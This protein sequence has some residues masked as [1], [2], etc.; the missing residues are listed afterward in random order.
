MELPSPDKNTEQSIGTRL[1]TVDEQPPL[2]PNEEIDAQTAQCVGCFALID[3]P[4][5]FR[6]TAVASCRN[7]TTLQ[8][9]NSLRRLAAADDPIVLLRPYNTFAPRFVAQGASFPEDC[10]QTIK[11]ARIEKS[12][13]QTEHAPKKQK[14]NGIRPEEVERCLTCYAQ[15]KTPDDANIAANTIA[16]CLGKDRQRVGE[17]IKQ[18][19]DAETPLVEKAAD[20]TTRLTTHAFEVAGSQ[21]IECPR[22]DERRQTVINSIMGCLRCLATTPGTATDT[23]SA[24]DIA[25][26]RGFL[27]SD[28]EDAFANEDLPM[29]TTRTPGVYRLAPETIPALKDMTTPIEEV[30]QT[31]DERFITWACETVE[32]STVNIQSNMLRAL[33]DGYITI[34]SRDTHKPAKGVPVHQTSRFLRTGPALD[35]LRESAQQAILHVLGLDE[36]VYGRRLDQG[37]LRMRLGI[38]NRTSLITYAQF[39]LQRLQD[40]R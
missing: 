1:S 33:E 26:C 9:T 13:D 31:C 22:I 32:A 8:A 24:Q 14:S 16:E 2:P 34:A 39:A 19:F 40:T 21:S 18:L 10:Y 6:A 27:M 25:D 38:S 4:E 20:K 7:I 11:V 15:R 36:L 17:I 23:I 29:V 5:P 3:S 37:S 12:E 28:I 30:S 35:G